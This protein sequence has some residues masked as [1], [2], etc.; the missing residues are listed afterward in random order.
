MA[1]VVV[2]SRYD[3]PGRYVRMSLPPFNAFLERYGDDVW[4]FL[5]ALVGPVDAEDCWQETFLAALKAYPRANPD[6]NLRA[7]V[8]TIAQRKAIDSMRGRKRRAQ[9]VAE[10][11]EKAVHD[12]HADSELWQKVHSLP[13]K[14]RLAVVHRYALDLRYADIGRLIGSSEA[15][16][17]RSVHEGIKRLREEVDVEG[18]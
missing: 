4:R 3:R 1:E 12:N 13:T 8:L 10:V 14:Q 5:R 18:Y 9:P 11:P 2:I 7:W 6:S 15:A 17:R 16:A